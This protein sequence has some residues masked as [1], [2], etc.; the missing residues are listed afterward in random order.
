MSPVQ[1]SCDRPPVFSHINHLETFFKGCPDEL[2]APLP[3]PLAAMRLPAAVLL[4]LLLHSAESGRRAPQYGARGRAWGGGKSRR[5]A[6]E[7]KEYIEAGEKYLDCQDQQLTTVM[8]DWPTDIQ[9]LLL[10]RNKIQVLRDNMFSQFTQLKSL[11]LQQND[12]SMVE[13]GAFAGLTQLTT[14]LLQHNGLRTASE[15]ILL[16]MRRLTYLR[17]YDNPWTCDC[18]LDSLVRTMQLPSNRNLGNYAK[19]AGP[20]SMRGHKLKKMNVELLCAPDRDGEVPSRPQI[21]VKP[22]VTSICRTY[23]FPKPLLDCSNKDLNHVP[24]GLPIDIVKMDLSGNSIRHLKPQQFLT[25]KDLKLLNL[26]RN[27]LQQIET[28]AF[29]GLLYLRELDLSNNSLH[30]FQYGVL[31]DLYFL[32]KLSLGNNPWV[33]D[34]NIHYLIYW[35]KHHPGVQYTGLICA[36][37]EEF[38]GWRVEDYVKTYNG[39]CPKDRQTGGMDTGQGA[40]GGTDNEAQEVA[41]ET[42]RGGLPQPLLRKR[43]N[44][45][46]IIRLS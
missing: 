28:A 32:R 14:L 45:I 8:Q 24:S 12:I 15:E 42:D 40:L 17:I 33:C 6:Q 21:K 3:L 39:E 10:A 13:D 25:C 18:S 29:A 46:E 35:L 16:P 43:I 27:S 2:E 22:E 4:L 19:C 31:E 36:E 1:H 11:D 34:Y 38:R 9:H 23:M 41:G 26:S 44:G 7:C 20:L 30:N 5:Q 37:P